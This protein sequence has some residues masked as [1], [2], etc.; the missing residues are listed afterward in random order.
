MFWQRSWV[1]WK[2]H[3]LQSNSFWSCADSNSF[4]PI[5]VKG[6]HP[7]EDVCN[8]SND[9]KT[10]KSLE[11]KQQGFSMTMAMD[12]FGAI[13]MRDSFTCFD[14]CVCAFFMLNVWLHI[15]HEHVGVSVCVCY[16]FT[17]YHFS[18]CLHILSLSAGWECWQVRYSDVV[19]WPGSLAAKIYFICELRCC[20]FIFLLH[21]NFSAT[22]CRYHCTCSW[23]G[24]WQTRRCLAHILR[25][26]D[27]DVMT[28]GDWSGGVERGL[29][30]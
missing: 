30:P 4:F 25:P 24:G 21:Y 8:P 29:D 27:W 18:V 19:R 10:W 23:V 22:Y 11:L 6:C 7:T 13:F 16:I 15:M 9:T 20:C 17:W 5:C 1:D 12:Y 2:A 3:P 28:E 14:L 26:S